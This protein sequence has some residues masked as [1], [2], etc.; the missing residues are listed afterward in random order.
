GYNLTIAPAASTCDGLL[1]LC[2]IKR[3]PLYL[4]PLYLFRAMT[5][6]L[7]DS[8]YYRETR[9]EEIII[10]GDFSTGHL[11]GD[12]C[13]FTSPVRARVI[14]GALRIIVPSR[15]GGR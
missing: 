7:A 2:I 12:P 11:D 10:E 5:R 8:P 3:P 14:P 6:R 9:H 4:L 15:T 13:T 1:D